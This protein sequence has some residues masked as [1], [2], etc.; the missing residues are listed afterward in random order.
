MFKVISWKIGE[1]GNRL[2]SFCDNQGLNINA[3]VLLVWRNPLTLSR[4]QDT[5]TQG[6]M[7]KA[8][9][10]GPKEYHTGQK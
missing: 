1:N 3:E 9:I 2:S 5:D 6:H 4:K 7:S 10:S 8:A